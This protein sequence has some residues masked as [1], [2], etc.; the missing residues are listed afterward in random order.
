MISSVKPA[1][2]EHPKT[3]FLPHLDPEQNYLRAIY[4]SSSRTA[5]LV[6]DLA[7]WAL[8]GTAVFLGVV[9]AN[10][11]SVSKIISAP[12]L[13][14]A[15]IALGF[16]VLVGA[17]VR[18]IGICVSQ[19]IRFT[20]TLYE[21]LLSDTGAKILSAIEPKF[22]EVLP[23]INEPFFGPMRWWMDYSLKKS[24]KDSIHAEKMFVKMVCWQLYL[25]AAQSILFVTGIIILASGMSG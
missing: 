1:D 12:A 4:L 13:K 3:F 15:L 14:W 16:S 6:S 11:E 7:V 25:G 2:Q 18:S 10:L 24:T 9:I 23:K 19:G 20:D 8:T 22:N 17:F 21:H 5:V